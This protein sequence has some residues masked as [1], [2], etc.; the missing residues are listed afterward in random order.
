MGIADR[1]E[2][3][4]VQF[5]YYKWRDQFLSNIDQLFEVFQ[6]ANRPKKGLD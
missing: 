6:K 2:Y 5:Q 1:N 3:Q 4:I